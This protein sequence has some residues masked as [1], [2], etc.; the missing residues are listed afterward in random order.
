MEGDSGA[1]RAGEGDG[2]T[3]FHFCDL[4]GG[5]SRK[6][7]VCEEAG[8]SCSAA[9]VDDSGANYVFN[10]GGADESPLDLNT[11]KVGIDDFEILKL[12][13]QGGYGK[14]Y[15]VRK[16]DTDE[17]FA[18]KVMDKSFLLESGSVE[19]TRIERDILR[20]V[21]HPFVVSLYYAFQNKKKV[22][23][24]MDYMNGGQLF[25]H[26]R[27]EAMFSE[28]LVQFYAAEIVLALQHLHQDLDVIH[29][30]LKPENILLGSDGHISLTDF[31][32]AKD[33]MSERS[34]TSTFC[35]TVE[36]MAPE[37]VSGEGYHQSA[38]WWSLGVLMYDML[39]GSPPWTSKNQGV[40]QKKIRE[41]KLRMPPYISPEANSIIRGFLTKDVKKRLGSGPKGIQEIKNHRFFKG[42]NWRKLLNKEL[43]PPFKPRIEKGQLDCA[44]FD[45]RFT[46]QTAFDTP[47]NSLDGLSTS[48]DQLFFGFSYVRSSSPKSFGSVEDVT[49][50]HSLQAF[51]PPSTAP[52]ERL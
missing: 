18:M 12:I 10:N 8:G 15:Q 2:D 50:A 36:Y 4:G 22:Y 30:D 9:A 20:T 17:I 38:D 49:E 35:G 28:N 48:Q 39:T 11:S 43:D 1:L 26:L 47:V 25:Y 21:R 51:S 29:R 19:G 31:G 7:S 24:V 14:V 40:L 6:N 5:A 41:A 23:L 27:E 42:I 34:K 52:S 33:N 44:H 13:G 46:E 45:K 16:K 37:M 32:L 3:M